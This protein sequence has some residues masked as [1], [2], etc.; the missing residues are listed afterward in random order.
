LRAKATA[1]EVISSS[2]V[3]C[4]AASASG[5]NGSLEISAVTPPS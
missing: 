5:R 4:S 2:R 1:I 3:V